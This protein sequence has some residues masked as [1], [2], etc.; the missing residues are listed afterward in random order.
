MTLTKNKDEQQASYQAERHFCYK[1]GE[2]GHLRKVCKKSKVLNQIN[3]SHSYSL[4]IPKS[5]TC[6]RPILRSPRTSTN[7]IWVS[8][9]LLDDLYGPIPRWVPNCAT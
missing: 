4:S 9:A 8:N 3:S 7:A 6:A 1:C 2:Q 5:Y